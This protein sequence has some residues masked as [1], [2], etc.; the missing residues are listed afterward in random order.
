MKKLILLFAVL[1][2]TTTYSQLDAIL[3]DTLSKT[4]E[5]YC[6]QLNVRSAVAAVTFPDGSTWEG[7]YGHCGNQ[8]T[9]NEMLFE[10]GSNTKTMVAA[11]TLLLEEEG[12][13][14]IDDT[15]Y[16]YLQPI[17]NVGNGITIKQLL[18]HTSGLF[19]YTSH[20]DFF[21]YINSN[22]NL[23]TSIDSTL[24]WFVDTPLYQ[25]GSKWEY[26]NTNYLL[27]GKLIEHI[28]GK[29]LHEVMRNRLFTP[30]ELDDS[31]LAF[32]ENHNGIH[33]G[34]WFGSSYDP[35]PSESFM[36]MAWAAGGVI[37]TAADLAKWAKVLYGGDVL[38]TTSYNKMIQLHPDGFGEGYGLGMAEW[39]YRGRKYYGHGGTTIQN[40]E[41]KYS[42]ESDFSVVVVVN[43]S[44]FYQ[45]PSVIQNKLIDIIEYHQKNFLSVAENTSLKD[46]I[47]VYPLPSSDFVKI[48]SRSQ[49]PMTSLS[50][51]N[52]SG[53]LVYSK[54]N[55]SASETLYKSELGTGMYFVKIQDIDGGITSKKIIFN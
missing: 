54:N 21:T 35:N 47:Q 6:D 11:I 18:N 20:P 2:S 49:R 19:S 53:Q 15:L 12:K 43:Q 10:A 5:K 29:P 4:L 25:P 55:P 38:S 13:I 28:E 17:K 51:F 27:L 7:A 50:V 26:C 33:T 34:S 41:M 45:Q 16:H 52:A 32:Y 23:F 39:E 14:S 30:N 44:G 37:C 24:E 42:V 3:G 36:S 9:T 31:Y 40:S 22:W 8:P 46:D 1:Y 48:T